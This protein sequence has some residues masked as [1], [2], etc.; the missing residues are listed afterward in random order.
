VLGRGF[1]GLSGP[2]IKPLALKV[3]YDVSRAVDVPVIGIGGI[4][5]ADDAM[6]FLLAGAR[7]V[8]VGTANYYR[9]TAAIDVLDG[10]PERLAALG[11]RSVDEIIGT[12]RVP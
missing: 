12:L 4:Q 3:V 2:C 10:L 1:G 8:Q 11:A 7:A 9:P 5:D 6:E